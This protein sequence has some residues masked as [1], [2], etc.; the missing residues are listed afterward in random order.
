MYT[1]PYINI[2]TAG[3]IRPKSRYFYYIF[4]VIIAECSLT[5][6]FTL[7]AITAIKWSAK[8]K[9]EQRI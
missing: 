1:L 7:L 5:V 2:W 4:N 3:A 9:L 8:F 6:N